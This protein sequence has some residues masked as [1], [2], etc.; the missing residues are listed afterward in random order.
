MTSQ[1]PLTSY[2]PE[3]S[4]PGEGGKVE[5][6][7]EYDRFARLVRTFTGAPTSTVAFM[8]SSEQVFL[9]ADGLPAE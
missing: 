1:R 4:G 2:R 6:I 5:P 9:G 7:A 8:T 3:S